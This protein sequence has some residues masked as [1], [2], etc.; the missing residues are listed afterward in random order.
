MKNFKITEIA[1][2]PK[3]TEPTIEDEFTMVTIV[4]EIESINDP[5]QLKIAAINLLMINL[6][7]Q[8]IIR[9]LCKRL[10]KSVESSDNVITTDHKGR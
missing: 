5:Q 6:Q 1:F 9:G 8:A 4:R 3:D 10:A 7:R 2:D